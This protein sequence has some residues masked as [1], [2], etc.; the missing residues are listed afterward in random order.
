MEQWLRQMI[1]SSPST[2]TPHIKRETNQ[3]TPPTSSSSVPKRKR[4]R[5][6]TKQ[7]Q[8]ELPFHGSLDTPGSGAQDRLERLNKEERSKS[9]SRGTIETLAWLGRLGSRQEVD[10]N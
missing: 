4:K 7:L 1:K 3:E 9:R 5:L 6:T 8:E 10:E 2:P